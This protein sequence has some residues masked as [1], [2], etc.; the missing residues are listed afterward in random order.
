MSIRKR[1]GSDA[2]YIDF[3]TPGDGRVRQ[4]SGTTDR[5]AAQELH[6]KL[7]H[8]AWRVAKLGDK[9]ARTFDEAALRYLTEQAGKADYRTKV[10]HIKFW[11]SVFAGVRLTEITRDAILATLPERAAQRGC[12]KPLKP[13]TRNRYLATIRG[14]LND[15]AQEWEWIER[16]PKLSTAKEPTGRIRWITR[17][18]ARRLLTAI[19]LDWMRDVTAFGFA[20]GLR[21]SNIVE[22]EW[23]QVDLKARRAWVHADQAKARKPIGVPLNADA[24]GVLRRQLGK[25]ERYVFACEGVAPWYWDTKRWH[26]ACKRASIE[27]FRFHD[28]RHTWASW[29]VQGGTPLNRLMELG[30]WASYEMVLRYAHLAPDHLQPHADAVLMGSEQAVARL[31][32]VE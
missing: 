8:E 16:A 24:V 15:A 23:S 5:R 9:P 29:H 11:R 10:R 17:D 27:R 26:A 32:V 1:P 12:D 14:M 4:T 28:V 2:W 7:K 13:A 22:W 21:Q 18:E 20:T 19:D 6:D 25:H 3:R 31:A 30:G